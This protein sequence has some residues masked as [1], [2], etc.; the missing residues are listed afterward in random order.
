MSR[1]A[2]A[3]G[4]TGAGALLRES[5]EVISQLVKA[6][7][8]VTVFIS[9]AGEQVVNMYG[10]RKILESTVKGEYPTGIIYESREPP[11][12]PST[13]RLYLGVY[14]IVV[15]SP[16]TMNTIGK[17]V[18]GIADTLV[19]NLVMHAIKTQKPI[20]IIPVDAFETRS[21][22]P[23]VVDREKCIECEKCYAAMSCPTGA[24]VEDPYYKVDVY[25]EKCNRCYMCLKTCPF[26]AISFDV[27]L[28]V[29]PVPFYLDIIRKL[30]LIPG[31]RVIRDPREILVELGVKQ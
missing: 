30:E 4:I 11:G 31:V 8:R 24:L 1:Q 16:A 21:Y 23:I 9:R 2:I 20:Y 22:I 25:L 15:V 28:V 10:L 14:K 26:N 6:G 17:I 7:Y 13:G 3:W 18:S 29:K 27:E 5:V 12:F 19:S